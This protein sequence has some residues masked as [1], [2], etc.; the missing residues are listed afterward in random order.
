MDEDADLSDHDYESI[1]GR[2][3]MQA[4]VLARLDAILQR[5]EARSTAV[6]EEV[7]RL[8]MLLREDVPQE[9]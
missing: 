7:A 9:G 8:K 1:Y 3:A 4:R 6:S 5:I 2:E